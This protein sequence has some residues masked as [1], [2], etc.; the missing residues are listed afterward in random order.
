[1]ILSLSEI[2]PKIPK[3]V[4]SRPEVDLHSSSRAYRGR[5]YDAEC[6]AHQS[7]YQPRAE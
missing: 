4:C 1:M 3:A 2:R 7:R 5:S 6:L